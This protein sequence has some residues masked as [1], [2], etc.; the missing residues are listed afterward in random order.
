MSSVTCSL[1]S[2]ATLGMG[3]SFGRQPG[4]LPSQRR[5]REAPR[6]PRTYCFHS[7]VGLRRSFARQERTV[8]TTDNGK[9]S[10]DD[11]D[12]AD[13]AFICRMNL[14]LGRLMHPGRLGTL[15]DYALRQ[16]EAGLADLAEVRRLLAEAPADGPHPA[17]E[18]LARAIERLG[19]LGEDLD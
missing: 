18:P 12:H 15:A 13:A 19:A 7:L 17:A 2:S 6:L 5:P 1:I 4:E 14:T 8:M 3:P 16:V 9:T 10:D 11:L